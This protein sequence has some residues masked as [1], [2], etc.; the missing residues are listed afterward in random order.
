MSTFCRSCGIGRMIRSTR[1]FRVSWCSRCFWIELPKVPPRGKEKSCPRC[2][3]TL[4]FEFDDL[5]TP[6]GRRALNFRYACAE[7]GD[8]RPWG[9]DCYFCGAEE[10]LY[11]VRITELVYRRKGGYRTQDRLVVCEE[12][13][14]K[15]E[16]NFYDTQVDQVRYEWE[17]I[18]SPCCYYCHIPED[19]LREVFKSNREQDSLDLF[20]QLLC[21][22]CQ[23]RVKV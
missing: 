13:L 16:F 1:D 14:P 8:V 19:E 3:A 7:C 17:K 5:E 12:H 21:Q 6:E 2:H 22:R 4:K 15:V 18:E 20:I 23:G 9:D 10:N 11:D